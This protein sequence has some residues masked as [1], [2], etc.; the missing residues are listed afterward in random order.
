MD[1]FEYIPEIVSWPVNLVLLI[2]IMHSHLFSRFPKGLGAAT[3]T[4]E[5]EE[6][7]GVGVG[8]VVGFKST[9]R[10]SIVL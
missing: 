7:E 4:E 9:T 8:Q 2:R 5:Q 6:G 1:T 3:G 10:T